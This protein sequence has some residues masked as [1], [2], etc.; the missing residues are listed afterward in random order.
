MTWKD[1]MS[2]AGTP[3]IVPFSGED[4]TCITFQPDLK[5]FGMSTLDKDTVGLMRKR[6]Y[7]TLDFLSYRCMIWLEL[8]PL[9]SRFISITKRLT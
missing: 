3:N 8:C 5:R 7:F 2:N 6:V 9:S 1:N 4:F